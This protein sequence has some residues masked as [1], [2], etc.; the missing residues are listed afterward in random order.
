MNDPQGTP[1]GADW[2]IP[3]EASKPIRSAFCPLGF[4]SQPHWGQPDYRRTP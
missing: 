3:L 2:E 1:S 4:L